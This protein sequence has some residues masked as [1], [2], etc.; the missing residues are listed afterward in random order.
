MP[1]AGNPGKS[2]NWAVVTFVLGST[3]SYEYCQYKRRAERIQMKRSIEVVTQ[4]RRELARKAAEAAEVARKTAEESRRA[5]EMAAE[6]RR[7][8]LRL[9]Q[10]RVG[11]APK[12][13]YKVW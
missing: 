5:A 7:E 2:A 3:I 13:W 9:E 11:A 1:V 12:P 10:E 4:G 8:Q 6:E